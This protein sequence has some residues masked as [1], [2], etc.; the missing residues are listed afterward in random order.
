MLQSSLF[1]QIIVNLLHRILQLSPVDHVNG[2]VQ[3]NCTNS[4]SNKGISSGICAKSGH[5]AGSSPL[6]VEHPIQGVV[7]VQ[8]AARVLD[9]VEAHGL[10]GVAVA[11]CQLKL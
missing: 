9:A 2:V 1:I 3:P 8:H 10:F 4:I 5:S 7:E 6:I 11:L